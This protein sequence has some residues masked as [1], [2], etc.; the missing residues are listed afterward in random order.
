MVLSRSR[1]VTKARRCLHLL[2]RTEVKAASF[3]E[4]KD[5]MWQ[6]SAS[7][8]LLIKSLEPVSIFFELIG[9][10]SKSCHLW[11]KIRGLC[12]KL[13]KTHSSGLCFAQTQNL[14][15]ENQ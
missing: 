2:E 10:K 4:R 5:K 12:K 6:I 11:M 15:T 1:F 13:D 8:R 9:D 14:R 7:G 3:V